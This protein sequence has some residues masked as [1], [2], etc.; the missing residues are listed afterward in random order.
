MTVQNEFADDTVPTFRTYGA[1]GPV[2]VLVHGGP[3]APGGLAPV[4]RELAGEFRVIEPLQRLSGAVPLTVARHVA[5]LHDMLA[6]NCPGGPAALV[7]HSWGAMLALAFAAEHP[8]V[9]RSLVLVGC[10]TFDAGS[11]AVFD[12]T[13]E[14]RLTPA[15]RA[16]LRELPMSIADPD[17]RLCVTGQLLEDAYSYDLEPHVDETEYHDS[18]GH[19]ESWRDM[20]RL[21]R[22]GVYPARFTRIEAPVLMLHGAQDPH[23]GREICAS[24]RAVVP[25]LEYV[26]LPHCGHYP[27]WERQARQA[28]YDILRNWL[29]GNAA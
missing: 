22:E 26:E 19:A 15:V 13:V 3:G 12:A 21:Q 18:Q 16:R 20:I 23:P 6:C 11:R 8:H 9:A 27:W 24:L 29:G 14:R 25:H 7:G 10:G 2:L 5:D 4:C 1:A 28:F 17:V